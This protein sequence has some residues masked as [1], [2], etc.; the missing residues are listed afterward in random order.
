MLEGCCVWGV[1]QAPSGFVEPGERDSGPSVPE[2]KEVINVE[3]IFLG[4]LY[5]PSLSIIVIDNKGLICL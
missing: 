1:G 5:E 3:A 2:M 4:T